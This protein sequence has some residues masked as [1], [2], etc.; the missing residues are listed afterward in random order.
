MTALPQFDIYAVRY[1]FCKRTHA[2]C[3][4]HSDSHD[5][6]R[7]LDYFVW[8]VVGGDRAILVDTG[9][10]AETAKA[11]GRTFLQC[12]I[13]AVGKLGWPAEKLTD[14][15]ITHLHYDHAGNLARVPDVPIHIQEAELAFATSPAMRHRLVNA[16][17]NVDDVCEMV[18]RTYR[19][20]LRFHR[21]DSEICP[22]VELKLVGGHSRGLQFLRVHTRH[23]WMVLASDAAHFYDTFTERHPF[24]I[25]V[26]MVQTLDG[27]ERLAAAA[28]DPGL[29]IPGHDPDVLTRFP[30]GPLPDT[31]HITG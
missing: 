19:D 12:P 9:F 6:P 17:F 30:A 7:Q 22:G 29:I 21:G 18:R 14:I 24:P 25:V 15:A 4:L 13:E 5:V 31:V 16:P 3:F 11:R 23:G 1:G 27:Y 28:D 20:R 26:D 2:E 8:L 10:S